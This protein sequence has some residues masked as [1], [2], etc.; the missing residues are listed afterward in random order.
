MSIPLRYVSDEEADEEE[1]SDEED[2]SVD[3][4]DEE[5]EGDENA[6]P[7]Q[8]PPKKKLKTAPTADVKLPKKNAVTRC[9]QRE[10]PK[11]LPRRPPGRA[12]PRGSLLVAM[13][14]TTTTTSRNPLPV[15]PHSS[16]SP[17]PRKPLASTSRAIIATLS[18]FRTE[19][20]AAS[21][22]ALDLVC[23]GETG[24][25]GSLSAPVRVRNMLLSEFS[26]R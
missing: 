5:G 3:E 23:V 2:E 19:T 11:S 10:S 16:A 26:F 20:V 25:R 24:M 18:P 9:P 22:L 7:E 15:N 8:E 6:V 4:E 12:P 17:F 21:L 1:L 13:T 14:M